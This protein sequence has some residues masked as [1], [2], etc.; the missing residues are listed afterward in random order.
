M[1]QAGVQQLVVTISAAISAVGIPILI[2][3][4]W[5]LHEKQVEALRLFTFKEVEAQVAAMENTYIRIN[6]RLREYVA[7][8]ERQ[9]IDVPKAESE[10]RLEILRGSIRKLEQMS[11]IG[12]TD[13]SRDV[14]RQ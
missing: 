14:V 9:K 10:K 4:I 13:K 7:E 12:G 6:R 11:F 5:R 8:I 1:S 2:G 3:L